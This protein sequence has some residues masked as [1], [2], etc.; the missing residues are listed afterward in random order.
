MPRRTNVFQKVVYLIQQNLAGQA[1]VIESA[2][3]TDR[4]TGEQR[5][6]DVCIN[7]EIAGHKI[8]ISLECRDRQRKADVSWV[9]EMHGKHESLPTNYLVLVS[10]S[11][12]S[13]QAR[14]KARNY[15]IDTV[16]PE[17]L[18][19]DQAKAM[20]RRF[21]KARYTRL[22][23]LDIVNVKAVMGPTSTEGEEEI[24]ILDSQRN[25]NVYLENGRYI[26]AIGEYINM[27]IAGADYG[28]VIFDAPEDTKWFELSADWPGFSAQGSSGVLP[29]YF[30]KEEPSPHL[31]LIKRLTIEGNA[32]VGRSEMPIKMGKFKDIPYTWGQAAVDD[33]TTVVVATGI[34]T[35]DLKMRAQDL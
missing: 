32:K 24:R 3:L 22:D 35:G 15:G 17:T 12:F 28:Q 5:E 16:V 13:A 7:S 34:E 2:L 14:N 25:I 9:E 19:D 8:I 20:A 10:S 33:R 18:T 1:E 27:M 31:R 21:D 4:F 30:Q 23:F 11:G 26:C 29:I 6:V